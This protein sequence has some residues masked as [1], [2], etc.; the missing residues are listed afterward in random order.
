[1]DKNPFNALISEI[2]DISKENYKSD[3]YLGRVISPLP[4]LEIKTHNIVIDKDNILIDKWLLDR[5]N[6]LI[7]KTEGSHS[8]GTCVDGGGT[9]EGLHIHSSDSYVDV[10]SVGDRVVMLRTGDI[11]CVISKV[12][13]I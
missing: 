11:F 7:D 2:R 13:K 9:G 8:H 10:L 5:H 12:V 3:L 4:N 1:M 6:E